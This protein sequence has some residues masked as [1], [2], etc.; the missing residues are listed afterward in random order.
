MPR[1]MRGESVRDFELR[2]RRP[3]QGWERIVSCSGA[4]VET[5]SGE[6]LVFL[7]VYDLTERKRA[8]K[9]LQRAHDDLEQRVIERTEQLANSE[10]E[11]RSLAEAMP[12][13]VWITRADGWNIFF[14]QQWVN[15]T[16]LT[17]EESY[18]HGWNKPFHPD[19]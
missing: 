7:S 18:G 14:N 5:A 16:G 1:I 3:D 9:A 11:F 19:D 12:Q 15:F 17:L 4:M 2:L 6:R 10:K 13:I 8:E